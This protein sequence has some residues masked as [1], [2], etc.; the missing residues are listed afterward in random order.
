MLT[1]IKTSRY[2]DNSIPVIELSRALLSS[3]LTLGTI[4]GTCRLRKANLKIL[5]VQDV[6]KTWMMRRI[7]DEKHLRRRE[8]YVYISKEIV[9]RYNFRKTELACIIMTSHVT[10]TRLQ[11]C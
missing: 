11:S 1:G 3:C 2:D 6:R 7:T 9:T 10:I 8:N 4:L 5:N